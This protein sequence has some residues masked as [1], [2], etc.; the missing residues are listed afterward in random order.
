MK[1]SLGLNFTVKLVNF[2][3]S[4]LYICQNPYVIMSYSI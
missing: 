2:P 4:V 1:E 3:L